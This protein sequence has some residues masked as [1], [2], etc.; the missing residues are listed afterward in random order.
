MQKQ[1]TKL[2]ERMQGAAAISHDTNSLSYYT[3]LINKLK[4][5]DVAELSISWVENLLKPHPNSS[6]KEWN[7]RSNQVLFWFS[8]AERDPNKNHDASL[9]F[10]MKMLGASIYASIEFN[11]DQIAK[12]LLAEET[13]I[14]YTGDT[15]T[16]KDILNSFE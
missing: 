15:V 14:V 11:Q 8:L 1:K 16:V 4:P 9:M 10:G 12:D 6:Y 5:D 13:P 7:D 2:Y 3:E